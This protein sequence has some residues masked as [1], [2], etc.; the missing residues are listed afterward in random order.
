M[1]YTNC[2]YLHHFFSRLSVFLFYSVDR[3]FI[4]SKDNI[5]ACRRL[6]GYG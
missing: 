2:T 5:R 1:V 4:Y 3:S 6:D